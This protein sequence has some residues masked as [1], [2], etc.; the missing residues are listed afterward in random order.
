MQH[1]LLLFSRTVLGAGILSPLRGL[2]EWTTW[3]ATTHCP[4]Q[5][6]DLAER[7]RPAVT[8]FDAT[9]LPDVDLFQTIGQPRANPSEMIALPTLLRADE[10]LPPFPPLS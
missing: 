9:C 5:M 4:E 8:F 3:Q 6:G 10:E 7:Y 1:A 2:P